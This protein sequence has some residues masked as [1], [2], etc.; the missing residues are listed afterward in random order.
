ML[1]R[2][3]LVSDVHGN[4]PALRAVLGELD[5]EAIEQVVC[6]G[7]LLYGGPAPVECLELVRTR[8]WPVV[9]G[10][11]D[12]FAVDPATAEGSLEPVT[13]QQLEVAAWLRAR[14]S[15]EQVAAISAWPLS[16]E[17][18]LGHGHRL[19]AFH[20]T[21]G[22]Y[23]PLLLPT[24]AEGAFRAALGGV[25]ADICAGGHTHL[26]FV[27]RVGAS[28][29]VNPGSVGFGYDHEHA[30]E[31][32]ALDPWASYALITTSDSTLRIELRRVAFDASAVAAALREAGY[33]HAEAR[34]AMWDRAAPSAEGG[35]QPA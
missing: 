25:A 27:R 15:P 1:R 9:L 19:L 14:L 2:T 35:R 29:F 21:P 7:D 32:F 31:G 3:A 8:G 24:M 4:A 30:D 17:A 20:A 10:N 28:T 26:Q 33:P 22:S 18:D 34:A 12:A 11:A 13:P 6:L 16:V 23:H 5:R